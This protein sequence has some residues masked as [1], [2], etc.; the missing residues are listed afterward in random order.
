MGN[1]KDKTVVVTGGNAGLG[2]A[3]V[4][5]FAAAG[6]NVICVSRTAAGV[7]DGVSH[8]EADVTDDGSVSNAVESIV[9]AH[10]EIDVW[11][12]NV[13]KSTRT[14]FADCGIADYRDLMELNFY[15]AVRCTL[16]AMPH[17]ECTS[18]SVVHIGSLA[19][20]TGWQ[21]VSPYV[22]SKHALAG[23]AHQTRLEGPGNVHSLFVCPGPIR[24][25]DAGARYSDKAAGL[26]DAAAAPGAGAKVSGIE[27]T[28]LASKI[29]VAV[30]KRIP[31]I[32]L[33]WKSRLLFALLQI[34]PRWGDWLLG[35]FS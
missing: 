11:I 14:S 30:E 1:W 31:E 7:A 28:V 5:E 33:P 19:A 25:D 20:K 24:R 4:N 8:V 15:T 6:A 2:L 10:G 13:G 12:N 22:T 16:A 26:G 34:S 3:I 29:R 17:L 18:G 21:H 23:F 27:P 9:Q 32:V 35:K